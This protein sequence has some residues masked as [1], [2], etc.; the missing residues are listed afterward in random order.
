MCS[1]DGTVA[2]H[3]RGLSF[4]LETLG[5][6][7]RRRDVMRL[8]GAGALGA[9]GAVLLGAGAASASTSAVE[10]PN[11]TAGPYPGDGSNGPDVLEQS[12]VVRRDIR[13]SFGS[14]TTLAK[15]VPLTFV[16]KLVNTATRKPVKGLAVY[17]WHCDAAGDYSMYSSGITDENY[18]RGVQITGKKGRVRFVSIFPACYS[19]RW[20]HIH[21]EV[22]RNRRAALNDGT[23]LATSQLAFPRSAAAAVY[24]GSSLYSGSTANLNRV[25]LGSDNVFGD[26]GGV[27]Q[28]ASVSG[29]VA[30]GYR[31]Y[32][33]VPVDL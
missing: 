12:G 23:P 19:G 3:D 6:H 11:E 24:S 18:L 32:L 22:Y 1:D 10:I 26:D 13:R 28:L 7:Q 30:K 16:F 15:G 25:S 14:S 2:D 33:K 17:A 4:D 29:S 9:G 5:R 31:A 8:M 21:F 20:P 27:R